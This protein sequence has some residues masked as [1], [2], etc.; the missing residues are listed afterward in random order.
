MNTRQVVCLAILAMAIPAY[1][2]GKA[3]VEVSGSL[4]V[5][6]G[7]SVAAPTVAAGNPSAPAVAEANPSAPAV[8]ANAGATVALAAPVLDV[9]VRKVPIVTVAD[10]PCQKVCKDQCSITL[11]KTCNMV[12]VTQKQCET[13]TKPVTKRMCSKKCSIMTPAI[14]VP[15]ESPAVVANPSKPAVANP[16]AP[17][18]ASATVGVTAGLEAK[19]GM[20][21][22]M[23]GAGVDISK[24]GSLAVSVGNRKLQGLL[25]PLAAKAVVAKAVGAKLAAA[26][27]V[28]GS[29]HCE[30]VCEDVESTVS[31]L[32][33]KDVTS[34]VEKCAYAPKRSCQQEC[35][36]I[37]MKSV[38]LNIPVKPIQVSMAAGN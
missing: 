16:S 7:L 15:A 22:Q 38:S 29:L 20:S 9:K 31:E 17:V 25:L 37:P 35:I 23:S 10:A 34:E 3:G 14:E 28:A 30:D 1:A 36:C 6:K 18:E 19:A 13:V 5:S 26:G 12:P 21:T 27:E 24:S 11:E 2:T 33:C 8:E 32:V 4:S